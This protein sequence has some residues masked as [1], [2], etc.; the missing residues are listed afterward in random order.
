MNI[1]TREYEDVFNEVKDWIE[2][3]ENPF[4]WEQAI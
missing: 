1:T 2:V 4:K 3:I